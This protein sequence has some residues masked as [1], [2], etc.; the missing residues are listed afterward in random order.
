[1]LEQEDEEARKDREF[2]EKLERDRQE[3]LEKTEKRRK[4]RQR[5]REAKIRKKNLEKA[6][7]ATNLKAQTDEADDEF[8]YEPESNSDDPKQAEEDPA[9]K[10]PKLDIPNDGSFLER[11]KKQIEEETNVDSRKMAVQ[12]IAQR[13]P[14]EAEDDDSDVGC[15]EPP[16]ICPESH[17]SDKGHPES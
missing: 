12:E 11:M 4:K 17:K 8:T 6:G 15:S 7:I 2:R 16:L 14:G 1:M 3:E 5:Q 13:K 10:Q 9:K